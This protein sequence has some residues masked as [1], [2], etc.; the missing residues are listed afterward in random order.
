LKAIFY[1]TQ[2]DQQM[3]ICIYHIMRYRRVW[4]AITIINLLQFNVNKIAF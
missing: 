4:S 2:K 1:F 3:H